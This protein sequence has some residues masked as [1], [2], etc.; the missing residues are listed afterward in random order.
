MTANQAYKI[1]GSQ[2][3]FK[4][5]LNEQR[6][7][8][9][10]ISEQE[11]VMFNAVGEIEDESPTIKAKTVTNNF[12]GVIAVGILLYGIYLVTKNSG[13]VISE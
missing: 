1:S 6:L 12:I 10:Y 11:Q 3:T 5:W 7:Q 4:E 8:G 9:N 2:L 13:E